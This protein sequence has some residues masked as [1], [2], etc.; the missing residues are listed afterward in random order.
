MHSTSEFAKMFLSKC[1]C[2]ICIDEKLQYIA[3][4]QQPIFLC[5]PTKLRKMWWMGSW[6]HEPVPALYI[7]ISLS[8]S[9][10][11]YIPVNIS[12]FTSIPKAFLSEKQEPLSAWDK[13]YEPNALTWLHRFGVQWNVPIRCQGEYHLG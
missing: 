10:Y 6:T 12:Q 8:L 4:G 2:T 7:Y 9:I 11:I 5:C 3:E 13:G 1:V